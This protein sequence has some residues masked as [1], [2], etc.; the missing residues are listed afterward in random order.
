V[1][2]KTD[3]CSL[4]DFSTLEFLVAMEPGSLTKVGSGSL[5]LRVLNFLVQP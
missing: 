4:F 2:A 5:R 3:A 1:K